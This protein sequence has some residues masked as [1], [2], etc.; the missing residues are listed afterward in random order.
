MSRAGMGAR[1]DPG[2]PLSRRRTRFHEWT[3]QYR[4]TDELAIE[5]LLSPPASKRQARAVPVPRV[6]PS[7]ERTLARRLVH[8]R[9]RRS[10]RG[11]A[12]VVQAAPDFQASPCAQTY[13]RAGKR[14][15]KRPRQRAFVIPFAVIG[16]VLPGSPPGGSSSNI[17]FGARDSA[18]AASGSSPLASRVMELSSAASPTVSRRSS[19]HPLSG[20][21]SRTPTRRDRLLRPL[22]PLL[23]RRAR[24]VPPP[25]G[26]AP[27]TWRANS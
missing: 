9:R 7:G 19:S 6:P 12:A 10:R 13:N 4:T 23:R 22:P 25:S 26:H 20:S 24:R 27:G 2:L 21:G 14:A 5:L 18:R 17:R 11:Q 1:R 16:L 3:I 15:T 8:A